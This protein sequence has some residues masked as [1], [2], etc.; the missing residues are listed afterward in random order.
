ML[1]YYYCDKTPEVTHREKKF[2]EV[3][4]QRLSP[5]LLGFVCFFETV[6][7]QHI[8]VGACG[9]GGL[10]PWW[11]PESKEKRRPAP[12]NSL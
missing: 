4:F 9:A 12:H 3:L 1:A 8:I 11:Q 2:S 10:F 7:A 5:Q 6:A